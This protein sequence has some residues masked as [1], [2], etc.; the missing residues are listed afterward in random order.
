MQDHV[1]GFHEYQTAMFE[2]SCRRRRLVRWVWLFSGLAV[3]A[4]WD[5]IDQIVLTRID[6]VLGGFGIDWGVIAILGSALM[7]IF[8]RWDDRQ[9]ARLEELA[10][11]HAA[12]ERYATQLEAARAT[13]R[14]VAHNL[15][16]PLTVIHSEA[17]LLHEMPP[18]EWK[19][20]DLENILKATDRAAAIVRQ[21]VKLTS[22][23]TVAYAGGAPMVDLNHATTSGQNR[24]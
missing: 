18:S 21:L 10:A 3:Y 19:A 14:A 22:Y 15:N 1:L 6:P 23:E 17:E 24:K 12:A 4:G 20:A 7:Y 11:R 16:Q 8:S 2:L 9:L 13:A 5:V